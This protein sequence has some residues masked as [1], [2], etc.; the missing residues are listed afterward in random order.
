M[1]ERVR[2]RES[3]RVWT[4]RP[5]ARDSGTGLQRWLPGFGKQYLGQATTFFFY[6][7]SEDSSAKDLWFYFWSYG[8]VADVYIPVRQDRRG[9]R[10]GF[11]RMSEVLDVKDIERKLN[12][13]WLG[14]YHLQVKLAD[15][16]KKGKEGTTMRQQTQIEKKWI[17]RDD[18][19]NPKVTYAQV[20][21]GHIAAIEDGNSLVPELRQDSEMK[22]KETEEKRIEKEG[23]QSKESEVVPETRS[24][25]SCQSVGKGA[26]RCFSKSELVLHFS[27]TEEEGEWLQRSWRAMVRSLDMVKQIQNRFNVDGLRVTVA[28]LRGRQVVLLDNS[29]GFFE[30]FMK[31]NRELLDYWFEWIQQSSLTTMP[32]ESRMVW[33]RFTGVPLKAWSD[34][35]FMELGGLIGEVILVDEDTKSKSF[36]CEGRVLI[37]SNDKHKISTKVTLMIDSQAFPVA[38]E[39]EWRMDLD[40]W[41]ARKRRNPATESD[42]EDSSDGYNDAN[43]NVDEFLGND[44]AV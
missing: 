12:Q 37:L 39:E 9:R 26:T 34:R 11:V 7:F 42:L 16:M 28:L 17:K 38:V 3:D 6:N 32:L 5:A 14:S 1:R 8:K 20:V 33:L 27:P 41:L 23:I 13:I 25:G 30:E 15:N 31:E 29:E 2:E 19:V 40:W 22:E 43:L 4:R 36:L 21:A 44:D 18:R 24:E 10:F 35:C